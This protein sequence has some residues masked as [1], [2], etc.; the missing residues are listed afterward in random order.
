[1]Q[2]AK[3][4]AQLK[5]KSAAIQASKIDENKLN[6]WMKENNIALPVGIIHGDE[7]KTRFIWGVKALPWLILTDKQHIVRAEGF[8]VNELD[9]E[10]TVLKEK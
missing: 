2:L 5:Q 7:D 3:Q 1:M 8:G 4:A 10:I 6:D 9:E